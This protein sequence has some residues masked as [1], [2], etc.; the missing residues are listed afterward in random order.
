MIPAPLTNSA[1]G[2]PRLLPPLPGTPKRDVKKAALD[3]D[4]SEREAELDATVKKLMV[5]LNALRAEL[6]WIK[7]G[8]AGRN[9]LQASVSP[10]RSSVPDQ[11]P[12][13]SQSKPTK[14]SAKK[15]PGA[16]KKKRSKKLL[17]AAKEGGWDHENTS[18]SE[19]EGMGDL[20]IFEEGQKPPQG[21]AGVAASTTP[22]VKSV[23]AKTS[24]ADTKE[25]PQASANS[26]DKRVLSTSASERLLKM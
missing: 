8:G 19:D 18:S 15:S 25:T 6:Q 14:S 7:S 5:E 1:S 22:E 21:T 11:G 3:I 26:G 4:R 13:A 24:N 20:G 16:Q 12:I 17:L 2:T 10:S 9:L 23:N